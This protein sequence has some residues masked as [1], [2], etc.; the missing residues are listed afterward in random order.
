MATLRELCQ[1]E[2]YFVRADQPV[3][4]AVQYMAERNIGAVAVLDGEKLAGIFSE[5]DVLNRVVAKRLDAAATPL[6]QVMT[7]NP[8]VIDVTASLKQCLHVMRTANCRHLPI[9]A[10]GRLAGMISLRDA[11]QANI[12]EKVEEIRMMRAYI[13]SLPPEAGQ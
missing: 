9:V 7:P 8:V 11:L 5:R 3:L 1:R 2:I 12:G 6:R 13:H 10:E 4:E